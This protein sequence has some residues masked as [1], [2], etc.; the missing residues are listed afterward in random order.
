MPEQRYILW[1]EGIGKAF[2]QIEAL[3][4]ASVWAEAGRVTTLMGRNGSGKTTL[5]RVAA[6]ALRADRGVVSFLGEVEHRPYLSRLAQLG[7][8]YLPQEQ[9]LASNYRVRDHFKAV[10]ST[11]PSN[12]VSEAIHQCGVEPLLPQWVGELSGGE[13]VRVSL[14]LAFARKPLVL[15][16]DEPLARLSPKDQELL[17]QLMRRLATRGTAV[18]TS[19]HDVRALL[20]ISDVIIWSVGGTTH[21]LG[22]PSSALA[23]DQFRREYLGPSY[24]AD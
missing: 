5:L 1:A 14:A 12:D 6:G 19:G 23:H 17:G 11:F 4:A 7:L 20:D 8:M 3:K 15:I 22:T 2:G 24:D 21:H 16:A 13:R 9:L 10:G 18:V